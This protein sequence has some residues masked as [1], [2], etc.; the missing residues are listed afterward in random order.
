MARIEWHGKEF[1][2]HVEREKIKWFYKIGMRGEAI[3]KQLI[4]NGQYRAVD[5]G[6]LM[7]SIT[8]EVDPAGRYIRIGTNVI[9]AIYVFLGT[10][11]MAARPVL[12]VMLHHLR[13]E[14]K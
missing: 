8:N 11:K 7:N 13:R 9:Y 5:T 10:V 6:R 12:R 4:A 1:E 14:L 3:A 2:Q